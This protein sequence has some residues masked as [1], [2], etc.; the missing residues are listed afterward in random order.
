MYLLSTAKVSTKGESV[1]IDGYNFKVV[2]DFAYL[3]SSINTDNDISLEIRRKVTL[4]N[5]IDVLL[6]LENEYLL[7]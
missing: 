4:A 5:I 6:R 2:K 1:E 3:R 7:I